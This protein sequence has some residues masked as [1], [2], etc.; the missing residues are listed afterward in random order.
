MARKAKEILMSQGY[1]EAEVAPFLADA[2]LVAHLEREEAQREQQQQELE[3]TRT[4]LKNTEEWYQKTALPK[5]EETNRAA[6]QARARAA[7]LEAQMKAETELGL[8]RVAEESGVGAGSGTGSGT[9]GGT[10]AGG[11]TGGGAPSPTSELDGRYV[12]ADNFNQVV[13]RVGEGMAYAADIPFE[14]QQLFGKPLEGGVRALRADFLKA[15]QTNGFQGNIYDYWQT[16]HNVTAKRAELDEKAKQD[17]EA[18]IRA[19]ERAKVNSEML[20]PNTAVFQSS[21]APF[22]R[23]VE[24]GGDGSGKMPWETS[25]EQRKQA[26]VMKFGN[27]VLNNRSA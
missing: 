12:T 4:V 19:D 14:H 22:A 3:Q 16:K 10:G 1:T 21:R 15:R 18:K 5:I 27:Q 2:R 25:P 23:K 11:G 17:Y 6:V 7:Q 9:G 24:Q 20:N 8:R 13:D 26:R